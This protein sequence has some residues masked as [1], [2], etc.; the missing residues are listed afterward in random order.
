L[1]LISITVG[2]VMMLMGAVRSVGDCDARRGGLANPLAGCIGIGMVERVE[3]GGPSHVELERVA[4]A[5]VE[6]AIVTSSEGLCQNRV[7]SIPSLV[8]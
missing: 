2:V 6:K 4:R 8:R 5:R 7:T 1:R 3:R